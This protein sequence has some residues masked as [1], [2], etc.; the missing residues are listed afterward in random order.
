MGYLSKTTGQ[1]INQVV[2]PGQGLSYI[3]YPYAGKLYI[4][5]SIF[6]QFNE[7]K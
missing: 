5:P 3:V 6:I 1:S 2:Q 4:F 7:I